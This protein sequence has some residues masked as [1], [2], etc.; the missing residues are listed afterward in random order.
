MIEPTDK[1]R[2][3]AK[4]IFNTGPWQYGEAERATVIE[5]IA[6]GIA[7]DRAITVKWLR[8]WADALERESQ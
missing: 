8:A 4:E 2:V 1:D 7:N 5:F 3:K 6:L